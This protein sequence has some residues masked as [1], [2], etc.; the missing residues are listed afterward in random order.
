MISGCILA[1]GSS[2]R[3]GNYP[4]GLLEV[5]AGTTIIKNSIQSLLESG[6]EDIAIV[7]DHRDA[8]SKLGY[9]VLSDLRTGLGPLAGI[10]TALTYFQTLCDGVLFLPCDLPGISAFELSRLKNAFVDSDSRVVFAATGQFSWHP[11]C[12]VVHTEAL[13]AIRDALD[14]GERKPRNVWKQLGGTA[15]QFPDSNAFTNINEPEDLARW[16]TQQESP[17]VSDFSAQPESQR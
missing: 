3:Y 4:K 16:I 10:E 17:C 15:V 14:N 13:G 6:I 8:Y 12:G 2:S 7:S 9:P 1:G 11:L 5:R